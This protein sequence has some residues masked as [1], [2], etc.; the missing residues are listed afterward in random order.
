MGHIEKGMSALSLEK[1]IMEA[2][3]ALGSV[4]QESEFLEWSGRRHESIIEAKV[5]I[6]LAEVMVCGS[7]GGYD[8]GQQPNGGEP[9]MAHKYDKLFARWY[10]LFKHYVKRPDTIS[11]AE[12]WAWHTVNDLKKAFTRKGK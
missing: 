10:W 11:V 2:G 6:E 3:Y 9:W 1:I 5:L 8:K 7:V 12:G 4:I